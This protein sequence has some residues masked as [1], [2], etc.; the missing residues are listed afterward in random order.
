MRSGCASKESG[1]A[2]RWILHPSYPL[3]PFWLGRLSGSLKSPPR[4]GRD[5]LQPKSP[6]GSKSS[7]ASCRRSNTSL[8]RRR[9]DSISPSACSPK[10]GR[11]VGRKLAQHPY[12][13]PPLSRAGDPAVGADPAVEQ[14]C[15]SALGALGDDRPG[16]HPYRRR[17]NRGLRHHSPATANRVLHPFGRS[18]RPTVH[19]ERLLA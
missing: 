13:H 19:G 3:S 9:S 14:S 10:A 15:A 4:L 17:K 6:A 11:K 12:G 18:R 7:S 2:D 8:R 1:R 5:H 16:R